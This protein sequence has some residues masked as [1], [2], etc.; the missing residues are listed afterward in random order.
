MIGLRMQSTLQPEPKNVSVK[1]GP[2]IL[3]LKME[4]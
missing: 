1:L 4:L 3:T 2:K